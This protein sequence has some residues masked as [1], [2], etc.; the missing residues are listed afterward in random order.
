M[1]SNA[2]LFLIFYK[3]IVKIGNKDF[4]GVIIHAYFLKNLL[5]A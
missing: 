4:H 2:L 3:T 5:V 1:P